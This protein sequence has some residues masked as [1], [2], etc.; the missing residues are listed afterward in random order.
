MMRGHKEE[1][2]MPKINVSDAAEVLKKNLVDPKVLR[3]I[4]EEFNLLAQPEL[5]D[6]KPE[7]VKKQTL[8]IISDPENT[9]PKRDYVGW[10]V[11]IPETESAA[12]V[13][14][15]LYRGVFDHNATKKG[16]LYPAKTV[17]EALENV[18]ARFFKEAD[19][20]IS[21]R[22][23]VLVIRSDNQIPKAEKE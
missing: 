22:T 14:D 17:G 8:L 1:I 10:A 18:P 7:A 23:P 5:G 3:Q 6:E 4:I 16:M 2:N 19:L 15:R 12:T 11:K 21:T 13:L 20:W 9:L